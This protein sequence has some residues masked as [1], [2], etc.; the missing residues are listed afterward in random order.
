MLGWSDHPGILP[1]DWLDLESEEA[2]FGA[3]E[4]LELIFVRTASSVASNFEVR[5]SSWGETEALAECFKP[6]TFR[7]CLGFDGSS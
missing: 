7:R 3:G 4:L 6:P 2:I 5:D 1:R